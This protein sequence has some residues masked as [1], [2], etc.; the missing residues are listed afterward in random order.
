MTEAGAVVEV[1]EHLRRARRG[2]VHQPCAP[3]TEAIREQV[4]ARGHLGLGV[5]RVRTGLAD[6]DPRDDGAIRR[7]VG[8]RI[9]HGQKI[10][11]LAR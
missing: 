8:R 2:E 6:L 3:G 7:R 11:C 10:T 1:R 5:M 9:D 4:A